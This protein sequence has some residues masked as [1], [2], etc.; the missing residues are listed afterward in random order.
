LA[1]GRNDLANSVLGWAPSHRKKSTVN[2][3]TNRGIKDVICN[4]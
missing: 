3:E 1:L 4:K 2:V